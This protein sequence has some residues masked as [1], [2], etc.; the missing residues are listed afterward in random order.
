MGFL[1]GCKAFTAAVVGGIG[2]IPGAMLGGLLVGLVESFAIGYVGGQWSDIVVFG[3]LI[4]LPAL[5]SERTARLHAPSRRYERQPDTP[6]AP[7]PPAE[8]ESSPQ[9]GVDSWVADARGPPGPS[10]DFAA[11][12]ARAWDVHRPIR[13]S[14]SLFVAL[15]ATLPFWLLT[16]EGDLFTFGLFTL[17]Y[18]GFGL[19]LNVVVG[20]AGLLDLGYVAYF[21]IGAYAYALLSSGYYGIHWPAEVVAPDRDGRRRD[22]GGD[23]SDSPRAG[24]SAT[25]SRS[26]RCSSRQAFLV[27]ANTANPRSSG[28]A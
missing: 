4:V 25:T 19:G 18:I 12:F 27:F 15:A 2:S 13:S 3:I 11:A 9:I 10:A 7:E 28:R 20:F 8:P 1:A 16:S 17:L 14:S 21:G 5:P 6:A 26:S 24:C 22:P 23:S